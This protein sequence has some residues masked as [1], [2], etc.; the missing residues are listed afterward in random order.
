MQQK[1]PSAVNLPNALTLF[2]LMLI[3][4]F[5]HLM[6]IDRMKA[7]LV[8]FLV[9]SLTDV[10]DG[11]IARKYNLITDFGK[12]FDPLADK[13]MVLSLLTMMAV[14]GIA[15]LSAIIVLLVKEMIMM[16]GGVLLLKK[17]LV[18]H[19][20]KIGKI[21]QF[22]TV[23]A[24]ILCFF[25]KEFETLGFPLHLWLLWIGVGLAIISLFYYAKT[26][27]V[28][29]FQKKPDENPKTNEGEK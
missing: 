22:V 26:N 25:H 16:I 6:N 3:P 10:L 8:V 23:V 19:A 29:L 14:K 18:V 24:L 20:E 4:V 13:L 7:A 21:A 2:R 12:L 1:K 17:N 11:W 28:K 5:I 15:P 9:A 27:G